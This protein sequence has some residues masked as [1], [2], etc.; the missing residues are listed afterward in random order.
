MIRL[1]STTTVVA[2]RR[3][4]LALIS[5]F[6]LQCSL[7]AAPMTYTGI[8]VTDVRVGTTFMHNASLTITFEGDTDNITPAPVTSY[9]CSGSPFYYLAKGV[10]HRR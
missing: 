6:A 1:I 3:F 10:T 7:R 2:L 9:Y 8:V 5:L 4:L